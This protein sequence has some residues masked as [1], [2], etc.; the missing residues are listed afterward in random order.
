MNK[1]YFTN[2]ILAKLEF[3]KKRFNDIS[4]IERR[5]GTEPI[6]EE[7]DYFFVKSLLNEINDLVLTLN[8]SGVYERELAKEFNDRVI[9][10]NENWKEYLLS[11]EIFMSL[12]DIFKD[13]LL[14]KNAATYFVN[15]D[16]RSVP[17]Q[18]QCK[19]ILN[20]PEDHDFKAFARAF[21]KPLS[22]LFDCFRL[23][24]YDKLSDCEIEDFFSA[25]QNLPNNIRYLELILKDGYAIER[26]SRLLYITSFGYFF[27]AGIHENNFRNGCNFMELM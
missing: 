27:K 6:F 3:D 4:K 14:A 15:K 19:E 12:T 17:L 5:F 20:L 10:V 7:T 22:N 24:F 23:F 1:Q 25:E 18:E 26:V 13:F 16:F 8:Y 21:S 11:S 9:L 2:F